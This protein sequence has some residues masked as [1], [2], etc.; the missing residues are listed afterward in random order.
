VSLGQA[1]DPAKA[2]APRHPKLERIAQHVF[3][4]ADGDTNGSLDPAEQAQADLRAQKAIR[5]LVH[6]NTIGGRDRLPSVAEPQLADPAAMTG[7]EFVRHFEALAASKDTDMRSSRI[8]KHQA[9]QVQPS[10]GQP[11][12]VPAVRDRD[13]DWDR[14]R[15]RDDDR[16]RDRR[17]HRDYSPPQT[18]FPPQPSTPSP[19]PRISPPVHRDTPAPR[20][21][22]SGGKHEPAQRHESHP[23]GEPPHGHG[24][25]HGK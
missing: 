20:H 15:D 14:D 19:Q 13:R 3:Q 2:P 10:L 4:L 11:P 16:Y 23:R 18:A 25:H 5:Q 17:S 1:A 12:V 9:L 21:H 6:D 22:E 24:G 8:A 7:P